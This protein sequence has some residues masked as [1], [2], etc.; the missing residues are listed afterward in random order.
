MSNQAVTDRDPCVA[1]PGDMSDIWK[2]GL[3]AE[4]AGIVWWNNPYPA[5]SK[6]AGEW[7]DGHTKARQVRAAGGVL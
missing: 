3:A 7:D 2:E 6:C 5:G 4:K 1:P